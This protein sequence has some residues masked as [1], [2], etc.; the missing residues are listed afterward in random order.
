MTSPV[1]V[2]LAGGAGT[3]FSG[4]KHK[5]ASDLGD[6]TTLLGA[7]V[8]SAVEA[9]I[10]PVIVILG[11][12]AVS[13]VALPDD[14]VVLTNP[15]WADGQATS[16]AV[17]VDWA[18]H[19]NC[20]ATVVGLGDQPGLTPTAWRAV[21]AEERTT[22]AVAT[23]SGCRGHPVRLAAEV[24]GDLPTTGDEGARALLAQRP[25]LVT[26]VPCTG[27]PGD[28]DTAEDLSSWRQNEA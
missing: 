3:R 27:D 16:L 4:P 1:A 5:L 17:A 23:Y 11:A 26:E 9:S 22:I 15:D 19:R 25:D 7:A 10:G 24:W 2:I 13:E 18:R 21:A 12:L 8:A 14:V 6:G 28:I 20:D